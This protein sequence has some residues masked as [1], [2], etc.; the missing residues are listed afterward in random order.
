MCLLRESHMKKLA[1]DVLLES[2]FEIIKN[3]NIAFFYTIP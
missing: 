1:V 2:Y 3:S